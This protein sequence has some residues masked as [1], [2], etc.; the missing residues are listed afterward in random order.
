[1]FKIADRI[2]THRHGRRAA[3]VRPQDFRMS[4]VVAIMTGASELPE[5]EWFK[6]PAN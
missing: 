1:V 6:G 5:E 3:I 2:H 4:E